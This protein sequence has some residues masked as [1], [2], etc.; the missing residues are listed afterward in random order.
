LHDPFQELP[1]RLVVLASGVSREIQ[2]NLRLRRHL[3]Q[4][5]QSFVFGFTIAAP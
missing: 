5:D 2:A 4:E 1:S 3:I